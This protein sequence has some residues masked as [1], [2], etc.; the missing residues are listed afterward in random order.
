MVSTTS[1]DL[2]L[3]VQK[4]SSSKTCSTEQ[5]LQEKEGSVANDT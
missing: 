5:A 1:A 4:A 2:V 3:D